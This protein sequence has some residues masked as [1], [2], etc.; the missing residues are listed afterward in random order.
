MSLPSQALRTRVCHYL[1]HELVGVGNCEANR[2]APCS[3][4]DV[5]PQRRAGSVRR[6]V[7][8]GVRGIRAH[9]QERPRCVGKQRC[10]YLVAPRS[11]WW[12]RIGGRRVPA[13]CQPVPSAGRGA[14][15]SR[16]R[17]TRCP[18]RRSGSSRNPEDP[19]RPRSQNPS[20]SRRAGRPR[21]GQRAPLLFACNQVGTGG[22][23]G[24]AA[25]DPHS[26]HIERRDHDHPR[27]RARAV[28]LHERPVVPR[29]VVPTAQRNAMVHRGAHRASH[30]TKT[31]CGGHTID[32]VGDP[33]ANARPVHGRGA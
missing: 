6:S 3:V 15:G 20:T 13:A 19:G 29:R 1:C 12:L 17:C 28:R 24:R 22:G 2:A 31:A 32:E 16:V 23:D 30:V 21:L 33:P 14:H 8:E 27:R 25:S 7:G 5:A 26:L 18:V 9:S 4:R 10:A 11:G